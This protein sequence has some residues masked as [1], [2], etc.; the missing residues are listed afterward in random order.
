MPTGRIRLAYAGL[1]LT[2]YAQ[3]ARL[4]VEMAESLTGG[5]DPLCASKVVIITRH[6]RM[7]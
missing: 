6:S 7:V 3:I 1:S 5:E 4:L 2:G